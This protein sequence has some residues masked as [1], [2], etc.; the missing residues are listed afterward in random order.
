MSNRTVYSPVSEW[1]NMNKGARLEE[2]RLRSGK[3]LTAEF[4]PDAPQYFETLCNGEILS[5][6]GADMIF[7]RG[8][9]VPDPA[10]AGITVKEE[11]DTI[12]ALK[13][14]TGR[15]VGIFLEPVPSK[16]SR[17][18]STGVSR[19]IAATPGNALKAAAY[20]V[21]MIVLI[22]NPETG[23]D[24]SSI[25]DTLKEFKKIIGDKVI[26]GTGK[27]YPDGNADEDPILSIDEIN[28]FVNNGADVIVLPSPGTIPGINQEWEASRIRQIHYRKR[29]AMSISGPVLNSQSQK[30]V[31]E[32]AVRS[33]QA[34]ADIH[35]IMGDGF[36]CMTS[37]DTVMNYS[38]ALK[39]KEETLFRIAASINR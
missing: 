39:G 18:A 22:V 6:A 13:H 4:D 9:N 31:M 16:E 3:T 28:G 21:D 37:Y 34:G 7:L 33:Y 11:K 1:L 23:G 15:P 36:F 29:I 27:I 19:F 14:L 10:I 20:G 5:A 12:R 8:F 17:K 35:H 2:I 32:A 38:L 30:L 25:N 26:L 24:T